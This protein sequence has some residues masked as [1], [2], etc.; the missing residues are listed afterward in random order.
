MHVALVEGKQIL[1]SFKDTQ[2]FQSIME[3]KSNSLRIDA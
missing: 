3:H 1:A 2:L